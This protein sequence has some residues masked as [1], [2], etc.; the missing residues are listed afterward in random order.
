MLV[1]CLFFLPET[2]YTRSPGS[3]DEILAELTENNDLNGVELKEFLKQGEVYCP[4]PL[5]L[6]TYCNRLKFWHASSERHI[7]A[8]DFVAK[9][10]SMLK[11]PS[12]AFPALF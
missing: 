11:Y 6:R 3:Y 5:K 1:V 12:V 7:K 4:P 8:R 2:I 10:L 9:P